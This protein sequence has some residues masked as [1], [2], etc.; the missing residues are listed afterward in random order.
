MAVFWF[1]VGY[2]NTGKELYPSL[3]AE[4]FDHFSQQN[5]HILIPGYSQL[6]AGVDPHRVDVYDPR[7]WVLNEFQLKNVEV[8]HALLL[9]QIKIGLRLQQAITWA[10]LIFSGGCARREAGDNSEGWSYWTAAR[11]ITELEHDYVVPEQCMQYRDRSFETC[12]NMLEALEGKPDILF[13]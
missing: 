2:M 4:E 12:G 6:R 9:L 10:R 13:A 7:S 5:V 8:E 3:S 1:L 11:R